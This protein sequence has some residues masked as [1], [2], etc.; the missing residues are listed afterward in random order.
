MT[1]NTKRLDD[2]LVSSSGSVLCTHCGTVVGTA[3]EWLKEALVRERP[4]QDGG[5]LVAED[6]A[7]YVNAP[8]VFRQF[9]CPG[10]LTALQTEILAV[11]DEGIRVKRLGGLAD[12]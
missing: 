6:P 12:E 5:S 2:N 3:N 7:V 4:A 8:V 9:F 10:C 11:A 1:T